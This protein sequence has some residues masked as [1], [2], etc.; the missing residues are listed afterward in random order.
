MWFTVVQGCLEKWAVMANLNN[1]PCHL[2][3]SS[4]Y[5]GKISKSTTYSKVI[6][7]HFN[8]LWQPW[9]I[10][11]NLLWKT[12]VSERFFYQLCNLFWRYLFQKAFTL[13]HSTI[14]T[15]YIIC[16]THL[17]HGKVAQF[18]RS[19][20]YYLTTHLVFLFFHS[21][22]YYLQQ[23]YWSR[24]KRDQKLCGVNVMKNVIKLHLFWAVL[25]CWERDKMSYHRPFWHSTE[26]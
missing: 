19:Q 20:M 16:T 12:L 14:S 17:R 21:D 8:T 15:G 10:I 6:A 18:C 7:S 5:L 2:G 26:F 11:Q 23:V 9:G 24:V 4:D 22:R 1:L 13:L 25:L 3:Y